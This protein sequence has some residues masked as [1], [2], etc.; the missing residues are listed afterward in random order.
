MAVQ[1]LNDMPDAAV[2]RGE[3][4]LPFQSW[5][6]P[7][8]TRTRS[9]GRPVFIAITLALHAVAALAF[10][11]MKHSARS[12][13]A[14]APIVASILDAPEPTEELPP[15][16]PPPMAQISYALP[17]LDVPTI[18]TESITPPPVATDAVAPVGAVVPPMVESVQYVR[19][20]APVYPNESKR[21]RERG[22]VLLRVLVD[23]AG[24]PAQI[25]VERSSGFERLDLAAREAVEKA[26]FRP[27]EVNGVPQAAQVLIP[28]EFMRRAS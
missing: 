22:T 12:E 27:H 15:M 21:R 20:P 1:I 17:T 14:P 11:S 19:Q 23:P 26:L 24:R 3:P 25:Q 16:T 13:S 28:I 7:S 2:D 8:I 4:A 18:E 5:S 10:V 6:P 9:A